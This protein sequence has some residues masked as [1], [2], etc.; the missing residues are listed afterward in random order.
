MLSLVI[1]VYKNEENLDR[2]LTELVRLQPRVS[3]GM[4]TVFVIDGSPDRCQEILAERLPRTGIRAQLIT[5]SRNFGSF[6]AI[7]AGLASGN[8]D[9]FAVLAADL[10]EPTDLV[11]EFN[12]IMR[13]DEADVV[14]GV[15]A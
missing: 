9:R 3:G 15:R 5:L 4:E 13:H 6:S 1:P 14:F 8:G 2:L 7:T 11:V 10:Q 12:D